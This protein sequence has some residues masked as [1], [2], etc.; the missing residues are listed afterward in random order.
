MKRKF[1]LICSIIL[2]FVS[3][4][5]KSEAI[6]FSVLQGPSAL[7]FCGLVNDEY[8][9][10][11]DYEIKVEPSPDIVLPLLLKGELDGTILPADKAEAVQEKNPGVFE[12]VSVCGEG[13]ISFVTVNPEIKSIE[14]AVNLGKEIYLPKGSTIPEK[15]LRLVFNSTKKTEKELAV[16]YQFFPPE[17]ISSLAAGK[18]EC[19]LLPEPFTTLAKQKVNGKLFIPFDF[20]K[21]Y[22]DVSGKE[23]YA[24]TVVVF[25]KDFIKNRKK[26]FEN[27]MNMFEESCKWVIEN[28][29]EAGINSE[30]MNIGIPA[31]LCEKS[32]PVSAICAK[33]IYEK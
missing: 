13:N 32:I 21:M 7:A 14:D 4:S 3:C 23:N 5:K 9:S 31:Q 25:R 30:K 6:H 28:P 1:F 18:I 24:F 33:R 19:A 20:Q 11:C 22:S 12:I 29:K 2:T 8:K 15:I 16:N 26:D 10:K 17:I 27:F